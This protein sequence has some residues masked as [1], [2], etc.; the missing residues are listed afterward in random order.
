MR[1]YFLLTSLLVMTMVQQLF[2]QPYHIDQSKPGP[3]A[4]VLF[5]D[6]ENEGVKLSSFEGTLADEIQ[7]FSL[8]GYS[9]LQPVDVFLLSRSDGKNLQINL[10]LST[11]NDKPLSSETNAEGYCQLSFRNYGGIGFEIRGE[12]GTEYTLLV[13][14]GKETSPQ[15]A[16]P[17][18]KASETEWEKLK[19]DGETASGEALQEKASGATDGS[20][21]L[22]YVIA[23]LLGIIVVLLALIVFRKRKGLSILLILLL[24][25]GSL[26][27]QEPERRDETEEEFRARMKEEV[28]AEVKA[29]FERFKAAKDHMGKVEGV[30]N[31]IEELRKIKKDYDSFISGYKGLGN[32]I[33]ST[34]P[35]GSPRVPSFCD[36]DSGTRVSGVS[37]GRESCASCFLDSR[38]RF[39]EARFTLAR[40]ETIYKCTK[41]M[42]SSAKAFGDSFSSATGSGIGWT[43]ARKNI[44]ASEKKLEE[45]YDAKYADLMRQLNSALVDMAVCEAK[46]GLEDWYD[47]FGFVYYEFMLD[48]YR[49]K[50]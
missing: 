21:I 14:V 24:W 43:S 15:F 20:G 33:A 17:F 49:R 38:T 9:E 8:N 50:D 12:P 27:G 16:S 42:T 34:P 32:C 45:A 40:L 31:K 44:E 47:R 30:A 7:R 3:Q 25:S 23:F 19:T 46:Y 2:S 18:Y 37:D 26:T 1:K 29:E 4:L 6:P 11:W 48:R 41:N 13:V 22:M 10:A 39:N 35:A 36:Y 28:K 5:D